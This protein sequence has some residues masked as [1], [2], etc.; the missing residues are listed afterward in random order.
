MSRSN[1]RFSFVWAVG[2]SLGMACSA[3]VVHAGSIGGTF[4]TGDTLTAGT[5][6]NIQSAVNDNDAKLSG[7]T[8]SALKTSIDDNTTAIG[9]N[10]AAIATINTTTIPAQTTD[11]TNLKGNLTGGPCVPNAGDDANSMVRVGSIC[12]DKY[13]ARATLG[14]CATD[15]TT[16]CASVIA[17]STAGSSAQ[18][19]ASWAQAARACANAGKRLLTPSEWVTGRSLGTLNGIADGSSE[20]VD[21][22]QSVVSPFMSVGRIGLNV[23]NSSAVSSG[24]GVVG[25]LV[26]D[27][28]TD[29]PAG[30]VGFRCAR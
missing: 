28:Y 9:V 29:Q 12:V 1:K 23:T 18:T 7:T 25:F 21:A 11:I 2:M 30:G 17:V 14:T 13:L 5:M 24:S 3:G 27:V 10:T 15:G 6:T 20:W 16:N 4:A 19:G 22:V 8:N 26:E